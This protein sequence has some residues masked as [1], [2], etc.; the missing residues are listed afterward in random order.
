MVKDSLSSEGHQAEDNADN[1]FDFFDSAELLEMTLSFDIREFLKTKNRPKYYDATLT[2]KVNAGDSISQLVKLKARGEMRRSYCS[3]PP[4]ML[5]IKNNGNK[6][7]KNLE[8]G[9]LK[10]V[11][12]CCQLPKYESYVLKE[13]LAYRL[14]NLVTPFSFKTRLVRIKYV[15]IHRP[16]KNF[17]AYGFLIENEDRLAERNHAV[18]I[19]NKNV[20]Q[21][22]MMPAEMARVALFNYMIGNT[23]W[24][25]PYQHNV[26]VLKSLDVLS[27]KGIPVAYD[28]DYSGL[29]NTSYSLPFEE[30]PIKSVT[31]RYYLGFCYSKDEINPVIDEFGELK[32]K[33][34]QTINDFDYLPESSRNQVAS[35]INSFYRVYRRQNI[36]ISDLNRTCKRF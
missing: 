19:E 8:G 4:I 13:Y 35:Y 36:L 3:F 6:A 14:Y 11:T 30:L 2:V 21:K 10:L 15:D 28:F 33:F 7:E 27:D 32:D 29:V 22:H 18:I 17:T 12:P 5:K 26:K 1:V 16:N 24:S 25:V 20:T 23:D 9:T 31:E 34:L